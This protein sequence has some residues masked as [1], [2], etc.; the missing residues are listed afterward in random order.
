MQMLLTTLCMCHTYLPLINECK[1][2][3]WQQLIQNYWKKTVDFHCNFVNNANVIATI[4]HAQ[5]SVAID[6]LM[7]TVSSA[8]NIAKTIGIHW[9]F[10]ISMQSCLHWTKLSKSGLP[11]FFAKM[12]N[13]IKV[14]IETP[15]VFWMCKRQ[16]KIH[17]TSMHMWLPTMCI[18]NDSL[19]ATN[20]CKQSCR[21]QLIQ[22]LKNW[23]FSLQ[24]CK[25][26]KRYWQHYVC[27][28]HICNW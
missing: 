11:P 6:K 1:Q 27:A 4:A 20:W 5:H 12:S 8:Q 21:H 9:V 28:T 24:F 2:T 23:W 13:L 26:C 18:C 16:S 10:W 17:T 3:C 22:L 7:Q 19:P 25:S 14:L 15:N